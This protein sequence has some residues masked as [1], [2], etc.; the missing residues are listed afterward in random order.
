[1]KTIT[2]SNLTAIANAYK[3]LENKD[4]ETCEAILKTLSE[5]EFYSDEFDVTITAS[6]NKSSLTKLAE[7]MVTDGHSEMLVDYLN[8]YDLRKENLKIEIELNVRSVEPV[9]FDTW[10]E[11]EDGDNKGHSDIYYSETF[12]I[13][14]TGVFGVRRPNGFDMPL[15]VSTAGRKIPEKWLDRKFGGQ[16]EFGKVYDYDNI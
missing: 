13:N 16:E 7:T 9:G 2:L 3:A 15:D 14:E 8:G 10:D 5:S 6:F 1:M 11:D 4:I 12:E